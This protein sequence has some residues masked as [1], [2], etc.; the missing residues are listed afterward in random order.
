MFRT[1]LPENPLTII[2]LNRDVFFGIKLR[3][4]A[5]ELGYDLTLVPTAE[6]LESD[7][8]T[9]SDHVAL[10]VID[11]NLIAE[12]I[13]WDIV[14]RIIVR[15]PEL[16]TLG[17]GS[18]TDVEIRRAAKSAGLT[19]IVSNGDFHKNAATLIQRYARIDPEAE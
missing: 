10:I 5:K 17:F 14:D 18:H 16:P 13:A 4:L 8:E 19:R 2:G 11:M 15:F 3:N 12:P 1:S 9:G 7:L 6:R